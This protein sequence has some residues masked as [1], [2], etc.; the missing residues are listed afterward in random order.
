MANVAEEVNAVEGVLWLYCVGGAVVGVWALG[1]VLTLVEVGVYLLTGRIA[2][3]K[4]YIGD[5]SRREQEVVDGEL[6]PRTRA[7]IQLWE[8]AEKRRQEAEK[9]RKDGEV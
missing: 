3:G 6:G 9:L 5:R 4:V 2:G 8:E 1:W 7:A